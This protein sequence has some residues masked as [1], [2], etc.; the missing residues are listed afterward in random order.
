MT[1]AMLRRLV[2]F[3]LFIPLISV[4]KEI[5]KP[6]SGKRAFVK[7]LANAFSEQQE[8]ELCE[9][10][11]QYFDTT[12]NQIAILIEPSL[13]GEPL[14]DYSLRVFRSWGLGEADKD[15]GILIY[16]ATADGKTH[17]HVGY[18]L[19]GAVPDFFSKRIIEKSMIPEF[20]K[21]NYFGGVD[22]ACD[23][24]IELASGEFKNDGRPSKGIPAWV[25]L[26]L[27]I[28]FFIIVI[29]FSKADRKTYSGRRPYIGRR[30]PYIG[31]GGGFPGGGGGFGGFGGFGGGSAGGGGA[32]GSW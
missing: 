1:L 3:L 7:D 5:P 8:I 20:K 28:L 9:K 15:N 2:L 26:L 13:E 22:A 6:N 31:G 18:G 32:S 21:G 14:Y 27:V 29:S 25:I 19:E 30:G 16:I 4:A 11:F 24:I 10:L 23:R 12:S 17:M